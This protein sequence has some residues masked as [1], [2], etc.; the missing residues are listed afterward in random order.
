MANL[1]RPQEKMPETA[2]LLRE[3][4]G[5]GDHVLLDD[6]VEEN[7]V[8][9]RYSS[10]YLGPNFI[11]AAVYSR[12]RRRHMANIL[13]EDIGSGHG[14]ALGRLGFTVDS[15]AANGPELSG[16]IYAMR[17]ANVVDVVIR[18]DEEAPFTP[19]S[20][21][22]FSLA[23]QLGIGDTWTDSAFDYVRD[24][25]L[26]VATITR[27][28]ESYETERLNITLQGIAATLGTT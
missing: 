27:P 1:V 8:V 4:V 7:G 26:R 2:H 5:S 10:Y 24:D 13:A 21:L 12:N 11:T 22:C 17:G 9:G 20:G 25:S 14:L 15:E 19:E 16:N 23:K 3:L 28:L 6:E 18:H